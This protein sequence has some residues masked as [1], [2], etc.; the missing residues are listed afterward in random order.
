VEVLKNAF[1]RGHLLRKGS[2]RCPLNRSYA[3]SLLRST[4]R[5]YFLNYLSIPDLALSFV[6]YLQG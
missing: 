4:T 2:A 5:L 1:R 3:V 6:L